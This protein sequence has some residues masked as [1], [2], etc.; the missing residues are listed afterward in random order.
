MTV[1]DRERVR[2]RRSFLLGTITGLILG[3]V[4]VCTYFLSG[5]SNSQTP[6]LPQTSVR[7]HGAEGVGI[8]RTQQASDTNLSEPAEHLPSPVGFGKIVRK[9]EPAVVSV[10]VLI[11]GQADDAAAEERGTGLPFGPPAQGRPGNVIVGLGSGFFI[12]SDG[13]AVTNN[14]VVENATDVQVTTAT[15]KKLAAKVIGTDP[16]TDLALI[17]VNGGPFEYLKLASGQPEVGDWVLA[18][19]NPFGL[20]ETVTAGIVSALGRSIAD[21]PY[22]DYIQIDAPVNRGNS[23]GPAIAMNGQVIGVNTAIYSPSGGSVGIAFDIPA[24]T[25]SEI[26]SQLKAHG[27]V[28]RGWLGVE[29]Q[30]LTPEIADALGLNKGKGVLIAGVSR[31]SPAA[32][33]GIAPGDVVTAVDGK[34]VNEPRQIVQQVGS[35][36]PGTKLTL[37]IER[38][39]AERK[40]V[41]ALG[42][43]PPASEMV[44]RGGLE[45]G[46]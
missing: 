43:V 10:R 37:T 31:N 44:G 2:G 23:G 17:K 15:G 35:M 3:A 12:S 22:E 18:I 38:K 34:P 36:Q 19:G 14:H 27:H 21:N 25:V 13:Y 45:N 46:R 16:K 41:I 29:L 9:V 8:E 4:G 24:T 6:N 20:G 33:A 26:V 30:A 28:T 11:N 5:A 39:G 32:K 42:N 1:S 7:S 40:D